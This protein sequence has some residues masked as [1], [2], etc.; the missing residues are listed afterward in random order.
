[1]NFNWITYDAEHKTIVD[2]WFDD[3]ARRFTAIDDSWENYVQ[4]WE[5]NSDSNKGEYFWS[6][7]ITDENKN[8]FGVIAVALS[9]DVFTIS[10]YVIDPQKRNKGYGS[11][12]LKELLL[13]SQ[14]IIGK[15]IKIANAVIFLS[16]IASQKAFEKAGFKYESIHSAGDAICYT[17]TAKKL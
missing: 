12:A 10:E 14:R 5:D 17:Y 7:M 16:N 6:I 8:P 1:M 11:S 4:Y 13:E 15:E 3:I 2:S 9:D